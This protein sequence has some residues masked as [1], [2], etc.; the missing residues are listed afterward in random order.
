[1]SSLIFSTDENQIF[2]ATDTLAVTPTGGPFM[3]VTKSVHIPHLRTIIA[4]TGAGGFANKWALE[5]S[6][7]M[8]LRGI[9]NLDFHTPAALRRLWEEYLCEYE[10]S[11]DITTTVYQFGISE[12]TNKVIS[13]AYRS[14]DTFKSES[15]QYGTGIKPECTLP[16]GEYSLIDAI[17]GMMEEQREIQA[18]EPPES[19]IYIGGEIQ[20]LYLNK[21]GCRSFKI[22]EFED[23][24]A[25][26][27]EIFENHA[28]GR[29]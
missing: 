7:R 18:K 28:R 22:G 27:Y 26:M 13:F 14:A 29:S 20:A 9:E 10:I 1:M 12:T 21:E 6:T 19:R 15:L 16:E 2:V 8:V 25:Q 4:G 11:D 23:F 17:H 5:V 24:N 3:F